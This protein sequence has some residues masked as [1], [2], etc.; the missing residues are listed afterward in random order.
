MVDLYD[1]SKKKDDQTLIETDIGKRKKEQFIENLKE[2]DTVNDLFAV[3]LKNPPRA[4]KKGTWFGLTVTDKTGEINVK[5]WG[6]ENKDRIKRLYD[7]FKV[8]DVVHVR[9][10]NVEVYEE[11]PQISINEAIGGLR[12]CS[13]NEYDIRDFVPSIDEEKIKKFFNIIKNEIDCVENPQL[14]ELLDL[15]FSDSDFVKNYCHSPSAITHHHNY[16]GGNLEH[17]IGVLRL[18]K[19][20]CEM[21]EGINKDL[22]ITGAILHDIGKLKEYE[23]KAAIEKTDEGNFIGHIVLGDRWVREKISQLKDKGKDF[24]KELEDKLCHIILSHHGKY[25]FGSP[26]MPKT[27]EAVVVHAADFMDSQ[28]KNFIQNIQEGR[29]I[30]EDDWSFIWDSDLGQKRLMYLGED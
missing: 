1:Y 30:S 2:G 19:N 14:K 8:G 3:K 6:G 21:Y 11:K 25:E 12:R 9:L 24:E 18:C 28:V 5:Y 27:I 16:V 26:R 29:R 4:Y 13:P 20:I 22:V 23:T 10:G 17:T 15:F 7:S